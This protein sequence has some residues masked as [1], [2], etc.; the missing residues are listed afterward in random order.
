MKKITIVI[1][2]VLL[3][4]VLLTTLKNSVSLNIGSKNTSNS[5]NATAIP[6][7]NN[8]NNLETIESTDGPVSVVVTPLDLGSQNWNF[9]ISLDTHSGAL[10]TNL[11]AVS[12]LVDDQGKLY[13]PT[14]WDGPPPEGHHI[15]GILKFN[16]I[17]PKPNSIELRI[18]NIG[19]VGQRSFKWNL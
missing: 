8:K 14:S 2:V 1:F 12:E 11:A 3:I 18:K 7:Q 19:G 10:D 13:K 17:S 4:V 9:E 5:N 15:K 16:P 6:A